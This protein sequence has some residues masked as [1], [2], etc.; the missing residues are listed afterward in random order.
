MLVQLA[1]FLPKPGMEILCKRTPRLGKNL[2]NSSLFL[3]VKQLGRPLRIM[4]HG[5]ASRVD[6]FPTTSNLFAMGLVQG[7]AIYQVG[8]CLILVCSLTVSTE[9]QRQLY[10]SPEYISH[11]RKTLGDVRLVLRASWSCGW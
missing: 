11:S 8:V 1:D 3:A 5:I 4:P 10:W 2:D 9:S 7:T 6:T